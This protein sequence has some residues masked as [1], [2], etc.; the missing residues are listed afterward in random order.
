MNDQDLVII[1]IMTEKWFGKIIFIF[2]LTGVYGL[3]L[4]VN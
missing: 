4:F 1:A 3:Y 2:N